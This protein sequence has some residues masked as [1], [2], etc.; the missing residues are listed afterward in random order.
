MIDLLHIGS[1]ALGDAHFTRMIHELR[2]GSLFGCHGTDDG[3]H[4]FKSIVIDVNVL[5]H[6][7]HSWNHPQKVFHIPHFLDLLYL[8]KEVIEAKLIF[9]NFF[10][11]LTRFFFI[12]LLLGTLH[13]R[14]HISHSQNT[15]GH[16]IRIENIKGFH[17]FTGTDKLDRFLN[18]FPNGKGGSPS[19]VTIQLGQ[20]HAIKVQTIVKSFGSIDCILPCHCIHHKKS[21][22]RCYGIV[23]GFDF[24][25]KRFIYSQTTGGIN[26][27]DIAVLHFSLRQSFQSNLYRVFFFSIGKY[28]NTHLLSNNF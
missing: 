27:Y 5:H 2:I 16:P 1:R 12:K 20:H 4:I 10:I 17:L 18:H 24:R 25:H 11:E 14:D 15:I 3:F 13:Q 21:F 28:R 22:L 19:G 23:N 9:G 7:T 26:Q 8:N 6:F